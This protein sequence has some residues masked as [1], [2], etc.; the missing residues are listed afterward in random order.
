ETLTGRRALTAAA[1]DSFVFEVTDGGR[2]KIAA[3]EARARGPGVVLSPSV[4]LRPAVQDGVFPTVAMACGPGEVAYLVELK[5]VF[6]GVGVRPAA[7]ALRLS[8]TWLP[9]AA[10]ELV[11][12]AGGDAWEVVA[13]SDAVL[14]RLAET[15]VPGELQR[16]L[17]TARAALDQSL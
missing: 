11:E 3:G 1:L 13:H 6:A 9:A 14:A 8:A 15:R 7:P 2:R 10:V 16:A 12:A 5:E 4:A 17:A